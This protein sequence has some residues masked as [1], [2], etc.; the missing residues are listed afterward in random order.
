M[1][2]EKNMIYNTGKLIFEGEFSYG[3]IKPIIYKFH[4]AQRIEPN[5]PPLYNR[6]IRP[7]EIN[8]I[9]NYKKN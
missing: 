8:R 5:S 7:S 3:Q 6:I 2:K 4:I 1:E 9:L